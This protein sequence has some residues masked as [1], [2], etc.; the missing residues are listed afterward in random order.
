[1]TGLLVGA[2]FATCVLATGYGVVRL[3]RLARGATALGLSPAVGLALPIVLTTWI[4]FVGLSPVAGTLMLIAGTGL[5]V[6]MAAVDWKDCRARIA[7]GGEFRLAFIL[8]LLSF[9][10]T[11]VVLGMG[12]NGIVVPISSDDGAHHVEIVNQLRRGDD[13][14]GWYPL[15]FHSTAAAF[16]QLVPQVDTALGTLGVGLGLAL[17]API[18]VFGLGVAILRRVPAAAAAAV[19]VGLTAQYPYHLQFWSGWPLAV[20]IILAIGVWA[21]AVQYLDRPG[22]G[23]ALLAALLAAG[24]LLTHGTELYTVGIGLLVVLLAGWRRVNWTVLWPRVLLAVLLIVALS[25]PYV[26]GLAEF[27]RGGGAQAAGDATLAGMSAPA[28]DTGWLLGTLQLLVDSLAGV[29]IDAPLRLFLVLVGGA[30]VFRARTGRLL[31]PLGLTFVALAMLFRALHSPA[32][33][34]LYALIFPWGQDYRLLMIA[35][36]CASLLGGS[37]LLAVAGWASRQRRG[38]SSPR[39]L[40]VPAV[41]AQVTMALMGVR[42]SAEFAYYLTYSRDDEAALSWLAQHIRSDELLVNDGSAD[43]GI[44]APYKAG[45]SILLPRVLPVPDAPRRQQVLGE[46]AD[47][48]NSPE[49]LVDACGLGARYIYVGAAGTLYDQRQLPAPATLQQSPALD[50]VFSHGAAAV[51]RLRCG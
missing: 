19:L 18:S 46:I 15:G 22:V 40:L 29:V 20:G 5:G 50:E 27:Y 36:I 7:T 44:W 25:A 49:G 28:A 30:A 16:L 39:A 2:L 45:A 6:A 1:V 33:D 41:L 8:V 32:V 23:W 43:A 10:V 38:L 17:L 9:V 37:G 42:F 3:T 13:W 48:Q 35:A 47:V 21:V 12:F 26:S 11:G 34:R 51:F 24:V 14:S 31:V 4:R